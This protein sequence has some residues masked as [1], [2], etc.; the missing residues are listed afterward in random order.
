ME[1]VREDLPE[2]ALGSSEARYE[3]VE[4]LGRGS[5]GVV[6]RVRDRMLVR[7]LAMK[8]LAR[9]PSSEQERSSLLGRF[10]EEARLNGRLDHPGIVPVHELGID[11][12]GRLFFTMKL[13]EGRTLREIFE[14]MHQGR[15]VWTQ[16][17]LLPILLRAAEAVAYAHAKGVIHRDLKPGNVMVGSFGEVYV[18]DWGLAR[19]LSEPDRRDLRLAVREDDSASISTLDGTVIGTPAYMPPEQA[20]GLIAEI[21]QRSDVYALGAILYHLLSGHMPY[22]DRGARAAHAVI[23]Q[24]ISGPPTPLIER[25]RSAPPELI[26]I[27]EKAMARDAGDRYPDVG[28]F[29]R[30]IEAFLDGRVVQ[31]YETG[32]LAESRKWIRR[33]PR[34]AA[35]L[36][37]SV[38]MLF[39]VLAVVLELKRRADSAADALSAQL[40]T[41]E[42]ERDR[43]L[44]LSDLGRWRELDAEERELWP[45]YPMLIPRMQKWLEETEA[46]ASRL[47]QHRLQRDSLR[48]AG[49]Q[50]TALGPGVSNRWLAGQFDLLVR[51]IEDLTDRERP[52]SRINTVV[53][54]LDQ[55]REMEYRS[56]E[57]DAA[58]AAW[59]ALRVELADPVRSAPYQGLSLPRRLGY[60]PLGRDPQSGLHEFAHLASGSAPARNA[61]GQLELSPQNGIVLVLI[62]GGRF[63][64]GASAAEREVRN[65]DPQAQPN[66]APVQELKL[67]A[68]FIA[69]HEVTVA[70]WRRVM[71]TDAQSSLLPATGISW[72][73]LLEFTRRMDLELPTEAQWE[74][75]ARA[76]RTM[77]WW[78]GRSPD[79]LRGLE[80][81]MLSP[82]RPPALANVG[83][84]SPNPWGLHDMLGNVAEWCRDADAPLDLSVQPV[85]GARLGGD[86][87]RRIVRGGD[88]ESGPGF[89][90][91]SRRRSLDAQTGEGLVG[92][93]GARRIWD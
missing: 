15:G 28:G 64:M 91:V 43:I 41:T 88:C 54:R 61:Q 45:P 50:A 47:P 29:V 20:Q 10:L 69:K 71:G 74:Y 18:V 79:S 36:V 53:A 86:P 7:E 3:R 57:S 35:L 84:L 37:G 6:W 32:A 62:P 31:A 33:H 59:E 26:A 52:N 40:Q 9:T 22:E 4:E 66:E 90:R 34:I 78:T 13:V 83:S 24:V 25:A 2:L 77:P 14:E 58:R 5:M 8:V 17:K 63:W 12:D 51:S 49:S 68:C 23:A 11:A 73:E 27:A 46:L 92:V 60:L 89:A 65:R 72:M 55:A 44:G 81:V 67:D 30:D 80:N 76:M 70:Q 21:G 85:D 1:V 39:V 82:A 93:R 16:A 48:G 38:L 75:A 42:T 56:L 87:D 19:V